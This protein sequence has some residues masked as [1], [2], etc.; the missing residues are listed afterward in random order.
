MLILIITDDDHVI[1][2]LSEFGVPGVSTLVF[3]N[4]LASSILYCDD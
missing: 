4:C 2:I 1:K 3:S